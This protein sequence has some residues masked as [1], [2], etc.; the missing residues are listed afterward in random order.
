MIPSQGIFFLVS[1][2]LQWKG[3][4]LG[5]HFDQPWINRSGLE[6]GAQLRAEAMSRMN[7][8][9]EC[10]EMS[11]RGLAVDEEQAAGT[12][13]TWHVLGF[14]VDHRLDLG[15]FDSM[16]G[17]QGRDIVHVAVIA[18]TKKRSPNFEK[19]GHLRHC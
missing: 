16:M 15:R 7:P 11:T 19:H 4:Q 6:A 17:I 2:H 9:R 3:H 13:Q 5:F 8:L 18:V 12:P 1:A 14:D 10:E